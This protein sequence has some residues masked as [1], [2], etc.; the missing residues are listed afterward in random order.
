VIDKQQEGLPL[1]LNSGSC[2]H[3]PDG[4]FFLIDLLPNECLLQRL[5]FRNERGNF[6]W[7]IDWQRHYLF[8]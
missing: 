1:I 2:A 8:K 6:S 4:T 5:L 7:I 3:K